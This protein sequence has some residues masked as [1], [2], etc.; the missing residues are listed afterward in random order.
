MKIEIKEVGELAR[1]LDVVIPGETVEA[2]M[3]KRLAEVG[4][5]VSIKGFRKG[6]VPADV[7]RSKFAEEVKAD[8]VDLLFKQSMSKAIDDNKLKLAGQ[9]KVT[10]LDFAED[11]S[12]IYKAEL[13]IFPEIGTVD[14]DGLKLQGAKLEVED[15]EVDEVLGQYRKDFSELKKLDRAAKA[16]DVVIADMTKKSD[17]KNSI[18]E[19]SFPNSQIDLANPVTIKEFR[20]Q[21][22]G[23]KA[24]DEKDIEVVY[25]DD[26]ADPNFAGARITYNCK[27]ISVNERILPEVDDALAKRIGLGETALEMKL[28][29]R[30]RMLQR[31]ESDQRQIHRRELIDLV[32]GKNEVPIPEGL[33]TDYLDNVVEDARKKGEEFDE[34]EFRERYRPIGIKSMRW[35]L[36]WHT[37][38]DQEKIEVLPEDTENWI[39][40][41]AA[42]HG[43][44][45]EQAK[46]SMQKAGKNRELIESILEEKVLN[47][48]M[49]KA[50]IV[51]AK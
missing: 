2:E 8:V 4:K 18:K 20:D 41:F 45:P 19:D 17:S 28:Q 12:M 51:P 48:L 42:Y 40:G 30:E 9:P 24:G 46:E 33:V 3:D 7:I 6:K 34:K 5:D 23:V 43:V 21:L 27:V 38:I 25:D 39:K 29:L 31:K 11:G 13:E 49:D 50:T 44:T 32:C 37:L 22:P 35:D 14:F 1:E 15:K 47:Y 36:L 16:T 26:Y 10:A